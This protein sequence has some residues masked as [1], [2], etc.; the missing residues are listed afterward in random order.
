[1]EKEDSNTRVW[2]REH[3]SSSGEIISALVMNKDKQ[4][5]QIKENNIFPKTL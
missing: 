2:V 4:S 1:M 3:L 5:S